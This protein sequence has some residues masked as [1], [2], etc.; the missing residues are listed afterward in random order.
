MR[1]CT[2]V[3]TELP[4]A[5]AFMAHEA[6][7][8]LRLRDGADSRSA[9]LRLRGDY[10]GVSDQQFKH[11]LDRVF[12]FKGVPPKMRFWDPRRPRS[13]DGNPQYFDL[14]TGKV[15]GT[16]Q[17]LG[18]FPLEDGNWYVTVYLAVSRTN[19][20]LFSFTEAIDVGKFMEQWLADPELVLHDYFKYEFDPKTASG[21]RPESPEFPKG[22]KTATPTE[23]T[24][25]DILG[26]Q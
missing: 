3:A 15:I 14:K 22:P 8:C 19:A 16:L 26:D 4:S 2:P 18:F 11:L 10:Y 5:P 13:G 6:M 25:D 9:A 1:T 12:P 21:L 24:L 23:L 20:R 7:L 17:D